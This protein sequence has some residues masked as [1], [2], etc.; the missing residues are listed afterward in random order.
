MVNINLLPW[1]DAKHRYEQS[2][3]RRILM[4]ALL[5]SILIILLLHAGLTWR[6]GAANAEQRQWH[7]AVTARSER[8]NVSAGRT[9][10]ISLHTLTGTEK[11][12]EALARVNA[13]DVCFSNVKQIERGVALT[14]YA[15]SAQELTEFLKNW[16]VSNLFS[17]IQVRQ[18]ELS[19]D[20]QAAQFQLIALERP[21]TREE[22]S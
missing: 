19:A 16:P 17:E 15:R 21:D 13:R 5:F 12:F 10:E 11:L 18:I 8:V 1:R 20:H 2:R 7:R 22:K 14:G 3:L 4:V 6:L 9:G